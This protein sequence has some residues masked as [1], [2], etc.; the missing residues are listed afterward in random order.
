[1]DSL[2][3]TEIGEMSRDEFLDIG[4]AVLK[5]KVKENHKKIADFWSNLKNTNQ[6]YRELRNIEESTGISPKT[7]A[8]FGAIILEPYAPEVFGTPEKKMSDSEK[9]EI[10]LDVL[11]WYIKREGLRILPKDQERRRLGNIASVTGVK[12]ERLMLFSNIF[13]KMVIDAAYPLPN[14]ST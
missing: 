14:R 1:M 13:M 11:M 6:I 10:S 2:K 12:L 7:M 9:G 5:N 3:T 8:N 4:T